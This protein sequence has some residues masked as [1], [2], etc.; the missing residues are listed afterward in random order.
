MSTEATKRTRALIVGLYGIENSG[1]RH[2]ASMLRE[3]GGYQADIL[4]FKDWRNNQVE[5]PSAREYGLLL[6]LVAEGAYDV[7]GLSFGS[8]YWRIAIELTRQIKARFGEKPFVLWGGLHTTLVPELCIPHADGLMV[9]EGEVPMLALMDRFETGQAL[10]DVPSLWLRRSDG[11]VLKNPIA[12]LISELDSLPQRQ[13]GGS[14]FFLIDHDRRQDGDPMIR[15]HEF[16]LFASRGCP[17]RCAYCYNSSLRAIYPEGRGNYHRRRTVDGVLSELRRARTLLPRMRWVKFDDDTFVFP[18]PWLEDF[19]AKYKAE[20]SD[21]PFDVLMTPDVARRDTL[22]ILKDAGMR[23]IQLGIEAGSDREQKEVYERT[24]TVKQVLEFDKM[25]LKLGLDV[26]YDVIIDNPM[27]LRADKEALF[28]LLMD[29]QSSYKIYLYSL[30]L[31]PKSA[32]TEK[33]IAL[34]HATEWDVEGYAT[35]SFRQFRVSVDWPRS[36]EDTWFLALFMLANKR[37]VPR[38]LVWHFHDSPFWAK[39]PHA[40]LEIAQAANLVRMARIAAEMLVRG[41][42]SWQKVKE[43]GKIRKMINQ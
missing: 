27:A 19:A 29:L 37:F 31:F 28:H 1:V 16:R 42:L 10:D 32:V 41:E 12:D 17:Y 34:G 43:Y 3:R 30:T 8:P 36:P 39:H 26:K 4:F 23:G 15:H 14:G 21:L 7:V 40:L 6:E 18:R 20:F 33:L 25:N 24:S 5:W 9:G 13:I 2:V 35:K 38:K 22:E 11:S